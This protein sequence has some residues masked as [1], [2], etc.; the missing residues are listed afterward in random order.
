ME[1]ITLPE[2][3]IAPENHWLFS[4]AMLVSGSVGTINDPVFFNKSSV[5]RFTVIYWYVSPKTPNF[6][7]MAYFQVLC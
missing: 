2:T 3:N 5:G 1:N 4:G 6:S 7:R